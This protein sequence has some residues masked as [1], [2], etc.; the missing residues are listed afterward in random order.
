MLML[1]FAVLFGTG[2]TGTVA[3]ANP[4]VEINGNPGVILPATSGESWTPSEEHLQAAEAAVAAE[5]LTADRPP[6]L[7][8]Y[9]QY[10]GI[11]VDGQRKVHI[12]SMCQAFDNWRTTLI[13]IEDG[14]PCFWGA[15]FNVETGELESLVVNGEG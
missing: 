14:G 9:R 13:E 8:G 12:N 5:A 6:V 1:L 7:D 11:I 10:T 2:A 4:E 3:V 15:T